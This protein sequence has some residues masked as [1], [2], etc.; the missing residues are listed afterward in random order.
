MTKKINAFVSVILV[1]D[2]HS[3]DS[4]N[5]V[6]KALDILRTKYDNYE[7]VVV[8][9]GISDPELKGLKLLLPE[10]SCLRIL[11]FSKTEETDTAIFAGIEA[12]IGDFIVILY[13]T[14]PIKMIPKFVENNMSTDI[15]FGISNNMQKKTFFEKIGTTLFY[16]YSRKY[17]NID[18]PPGSTYYMSLNRSAANALTKNNRVSRHIRQLA[19]MVGFNTK[20]LKYDLPVKSVYSHAKK[21]DLVAKALNLASGYSGQPLRFVSFLGVLAALLN[22]FYA[23]YVVAVGLSL[24]GVARGWTT[25]SLQSSIMF[26]LLFILIAVLAE[27]IGK[28]LV[29]SRKEPAYHIM[30]ELSSTISIADETRRNVTK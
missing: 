13:N 24:T 21:R 22:L 9:N 27:Y 28:I 11:R 12:A 5:R 3:K 10:V 17:M 19:T 2:Y 29:E 7:L 15:V 8:D 26:F 25:L 4:T 16:W 30:Q 23:V 18:I 14:D 20:N 6:K 1:A